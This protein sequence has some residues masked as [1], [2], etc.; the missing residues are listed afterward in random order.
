LRAE[1]LLK[2]LVG[3]K[4]E[5]SVSAWDPDPAEVAIE[6]ENVRALLLETIRRASHDW[7]LYRGSTRLQQRELAHDAYVWLFEEKPGHPNWELRKQEGKQLMAFLNICD[8]LDLDPGYVRETA[9]RL[10]PRHIKM[11]GR[12]AEKRRRQDGYD[13]VYY[14]EHSVETVSLESLEEF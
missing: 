4:E 14:S 3:V 7:V 10:T 6:A 9:K 12:P 13:S 1:A 8:I 11:A 2:E 5:E